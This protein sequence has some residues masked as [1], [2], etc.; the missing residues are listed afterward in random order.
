M[1][2]ENSSPLELAKFLL[3]EMVHINLQVLTTTVTL[4]MELALLEP[5]ADDPTW[6]GTSDILKQKTRLRNQYVAT[7]SSCGTLL[8]IS[9]WRCGLRQLI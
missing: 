5:D 1:E 3:L 7:K 9:Q 6:F 2:I 4:A 8:Y